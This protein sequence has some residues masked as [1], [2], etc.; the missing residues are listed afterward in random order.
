MLKNIYAIFFRI[1]NFNHLFYIYLNVYHG[2]RVSSRTTHHQFIYFF[3]VYELNAFY[4][5]HCCCCCCWPRLSICFCSSNLAVLFG[6][7]VDSMWLE[8]RL[9]SISVASRCCLLSCCYPHSP[10][11]LSFGPV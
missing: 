6:L 8:L 3:F 5:S 2:C 11:S 10:F 1:I 7:C 4:F 9:L